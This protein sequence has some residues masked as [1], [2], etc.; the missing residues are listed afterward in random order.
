MSS[1]EPYGF[2]EVPFPITPDHT[3]KHWA[4]REELR[5]ELLDVIDSPREDDIGLSEFVVLHGSYGAGKSHTLRYLRNYIQE[6][7]DAYRSKAIYVQSIRIE[8][9]ISFLALCKEIIRLLDNDYISEV[10]KDVLLYIEAKENDHPDALKLQ[11]QD[12]LREIVIQTFDRELHSMLKKLCKIAKENVVPVNELTSGIGSDFEAARELGAFFR[13]LNVCRTVS[14]L[15][16][17][18]ANYLFL[19]EIEAVTEVKVAES[20]AF[21]NGMLQF[22]N[23][24]P[25]NFCL[26][27]SFSGDAVLYEAVANEALVQRMTRDYIELPDLE[28][29]EAKDFLVK[30]FESY[31]TD[32]FNNSNLYHPFTEEAVDYVLGRTLPMTPRNIFRALRKVLERSVKRDNLAPGEEIQ[33]S[34]AERIL[35]K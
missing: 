22:I 30:Q 21:F 27:C 34:D 26:I 4:G 15:P 32:S 12:K 31:R 20:Q 17:S 13:C 5:K 16:L 1:F 28:P 35:G 18:E 29:D 3:T 24:L 7:R 33:K 10:S 9:R 14:D 23:Q 8:N 11:K 6:R 2:R 19:D 25:Y